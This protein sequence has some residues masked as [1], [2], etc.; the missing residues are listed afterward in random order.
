MYTKIDL[1]CFRSR[2]LLMTVGSSRKNEY[3]HPYMT[4]LRTIYP[5]QGLSYFTGIALLSRRQPRRDAETSFR[6]LAVS[7]VTW[8]QL[9]T[10]IVHKILS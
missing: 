2:M 1:L 4:T 5:L 10:G 3:I 9:L 6:L 7:K 8:S